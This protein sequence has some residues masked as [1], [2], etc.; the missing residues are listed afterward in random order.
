MTTHNERRLLPWSG[1]D[2][3]P[4][5]L[6]IEANGGYLSRLADQIESVQLDLAAELLEHAFEVLGDG[7]VGQ[8][9]LRCLTMD[10]TGALRDV[11]RVAISRGRRLPPMDPPAWEGDDEGPRLP[12]VAFG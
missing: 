9:E 2:G 6:T 5:Y 8:D 12:A 10:M 4:C 7:E 11:H 3:K 1:L